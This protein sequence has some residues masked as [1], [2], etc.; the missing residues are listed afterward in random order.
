MA[1]SRN[2]G[3]KVDSRALRGATASLLLA[4]LG[5][6]A[7]GGGDEP[8]SAATP[9]DVKR[10]LT[11]A[12]VDRDTVC[13]SNRYATARFA[14]LATYGVPEY[15]KRVTELCEK[16]VETYAAKSLKIT[17]VR[18]SGDRARARV[19]A[20]GGAY[21]FG[22]VTFELVRD[23]VWRVD[24]VAAVD[25]DRER[26]DAVQTRVATTT[27]PPATSAQL[28]CT[29]RVYGRSSDAELERAV[30]SF[31]PKFVTEPVLRCFLRPELRRQGLSA[32][33]ANCVI[34]TL[35]S[36]DG[37]LRVLLSED[38]KKLEALFTQAGADCAAG[39]AV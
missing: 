38:E 8:Q 37:F 9:Q 6:T 30:R 31:D 29:L 4:A 10:D 17:G 15:A 16:N 24:D 5:L 11:A 39:S 7:C 20:T 19:T 21:A 35:R 1:R 23:G 12:L 26:F 27:D 25:I 18:V 36:T 32:T 28:A 13:A 33:L 22:T 2:P 3:R 14:K 34:S